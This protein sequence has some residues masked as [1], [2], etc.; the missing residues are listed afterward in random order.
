MRVLPHSEDRIFFREAIQVPEATSKPTPPH[1]WKTE[2]QKLMWDNA[3]ALRKRVLEMVVGD[4][5]RLVSFLLN[6]CVLVVVSTESRGEALRIFRVL[7]DRGLAL[8][9]VDVIKAE[10]Q[11]TVE[12]ILPQTPAEGE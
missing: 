8:S 7:N 3:V 2:A 11:K 1:E 4:R 12:H 10:G 9:N 5:Q 6:N